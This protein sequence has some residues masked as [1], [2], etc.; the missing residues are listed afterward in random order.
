MSIDTLT[1]AGQLLQA[2]DTGNHL[3]DVMQRIVN[4]AQSNPDPQT[5][6]QQ[7]LSEIA[8]YSGADY[9][10]DKELAVSLLERVLEYNV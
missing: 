3:P 2:L 6:V 5:Y 1:L 9:D 8:V 10:D 7:I 4:E